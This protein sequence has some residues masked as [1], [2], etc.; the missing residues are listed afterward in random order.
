MKIKILLFV[1]FPILVFAQS[2]KFE[3]DSRTGKPIVVG[4]CTRQT[5]KDSSLGNWF[6]ENYNF[7]KPDTST[8]NKIK[9]KIPF[10]RIKI[11]MGTWCSDSRRE[12]PRFYKILDFLNFPA[13]N[14]ELIAVDRRKKGINGETKNLNIQRVP[15]FIFYFNGKEVGRIIESPVE[16]LEK[17]ISKILS[18]NKTL[19]EKE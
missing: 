4:V 17:D 9:P 16:T 19:P 3:K 12:V 6:E 1:L 10:Y 14:L 11:V 15:T 13:R 8:L 2:F 7:Y 18:K 5:L